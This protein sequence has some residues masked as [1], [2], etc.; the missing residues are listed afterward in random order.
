[1]RLALTILVLLVPGLAHAD[2]TTIVNIG[3]GI[4]AL[5][6]VDAIEP[7]G[8]GG[9]RV[10]LAWENAPL[11]IPAEEGTFDV[12]LALVPELVGGALIEE[13]RAEAYVGVGLR[14]ELKMAQ[15]AMGLLR[16]TTRGAAYVAARA[17]VMGETRDVTY[18]FGI[19][20]YFAG[21]TS[22]TRFGYEIEVLS[23]PHYEQTDR[24]FMGFQLLLYVGWAP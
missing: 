11:P 6:D 4:G 12:G 21:R 16:W 24:H 19:G 1:M 5:G 14:G 18:D 20:Q 7:D 22:F 10:V 23:R 8:A 17:L 9:P 15:N 3:A 2:R 13:D